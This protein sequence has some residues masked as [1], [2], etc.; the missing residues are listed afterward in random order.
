MRSLSSVTPLSPAARSLSG[1]NNGTSPSNY[2]SSYPVSP[3]N[4]F[5]GIDASRAKNLWLAIYDYSAQ[6][7]DELTLQKGDVIEVLSK[8]Y[9]ISGD[10]GWWT[11]KCNGKV[12]VFPCNFVAP[13][14]QDFSDLTQEELKR[15]YPPHISFSELEVCLR[16]IKDLQRLPTAFLLVSRSKK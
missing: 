12:G 7:E 16:L 11:G 13:A 9:K 2:S 4:N 10:E 8:D 15:F 1:N 6:G 5:E 14:D 3:N